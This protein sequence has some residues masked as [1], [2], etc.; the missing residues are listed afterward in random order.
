MKL[1]INI[2]TYP[3]AAM[4]AAATPQ[5]ME[6]PWTNCKNARTLPVRDVESRGGTP[7]HC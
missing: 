7:F 2:K 6:I 1:T 4:R 3:H 5:T